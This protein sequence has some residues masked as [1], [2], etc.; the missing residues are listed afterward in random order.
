MKQHIEQ[1]NHNSDFHNCICGSYPDK[2][3]DW[4]IIVL[5]Y[6]AFH[7]LKAL[8]AKT[9]IDI[10]STHHDIEMNVNP[11]FQR[12]DEHTMRIKKT[13]WE[14]YNSLF[15]YSQT[16]RYNGIIDAQTFEALKKEDYKRSLNH[17][18]SF[19]KYIILERQVPITNTIIGIDETQAN[20]KERFESQE[21]KSTNNN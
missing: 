7:Y 6:C 18:K 16:A 5:F 13:A 21:V 14:N 3:F 17:L 8:A 11:K 19:S 9:G 15:C 12:T 1:V 4:K 2:F 10:G 20:P